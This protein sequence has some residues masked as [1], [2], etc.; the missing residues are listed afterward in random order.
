[1]KNEQGYEITIEKE[2]LFSL[3]YGNLYSLKT[4]SKTISE[5]QIGRI[6]SDKT[7]KKISNKHKGMKLSKETILKI[8][9]SNHYKWKGGNTGRFRTN[10]K[11][12]QWCKQVK[13]RDGNICKLCKS[14]EQLHCHHIKPVSEYPELTLNIDNGIV[15]CKICH[16]YTHKISALSQQ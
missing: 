2:L 5:A 4:I 15:L 7:R 8:S 6:Y 10:W 1:M 13:K 3:Y 12:R 14:N 11:Y 16:I 9:G